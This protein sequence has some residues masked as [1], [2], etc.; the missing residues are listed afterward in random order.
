MLLGLVALL[1]PGSGAG[2]MLLVEHVRCA[3]HGELLHAGEAARHEL[4][5]HALGEPAGVHG[6]SQDLSGEGHEHCA[7][8]ADRR[9]ALA[10]IG[11]A[12]V[13]PVPPRDAP[14]SPPLAMLRADESGRF[15]VAPKNSPPA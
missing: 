2:H 1:L 3:A 10:P 14:A 7:P 8:S 13:H 4:G 6:S 11:C 15:R 5:D 12:E 9:D